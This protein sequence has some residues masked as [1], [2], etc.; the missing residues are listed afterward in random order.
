MTP[1]G[2]PPAAPPPPPGWTPPYVPEPPN[3]PANVGFA[4]SISAVGLLVFT[5]GVL[6]FVSLP[7]AIGGWIQGREGVRKV[8]RGETRKHEDLARAA[9]IIGIL[10]TILSAVALVAGIVLIAT[11][12]HGFHVRSN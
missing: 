1:P 6:S 5:L 7:L 4:L 2:I 12:P 3:K 11:H 9:V 10:T 8:E